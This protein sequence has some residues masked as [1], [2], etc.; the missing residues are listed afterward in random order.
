MDL[1]VAVGVDKVRFSVWKELDFRI[2]PCLYMYACEHT[3]VLAAIRMGQYTTL[4]C[5]SDKCS[6]RLGLLL[7]LLLFTPVCK[8]VCVCVCVWQGMGDGDFIQLIIS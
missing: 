5:T 4:C 1:D 6:M 2:L 7:R 8:L 3:C